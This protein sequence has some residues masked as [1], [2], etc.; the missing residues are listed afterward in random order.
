MVNDNPKAVIGGN[1]IDADFDYETE[2]QSN[3]FSRI[4]NRIDLI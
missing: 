3:F 4:K 2:E 1:P